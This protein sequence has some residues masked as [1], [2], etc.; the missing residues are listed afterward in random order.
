MRQRYIWLIIAGA[1]TVLVLACGGLSVAGYFVA[2]NVASSAFPNTEATFPE[3]Q[4]FELPSPAITADAAP[5]I[6]LE[7]DF[8]D[9]GSGWYTVTEPGVSIEYADGGYHFVLDE[10]ETGYWETHRSIRLRR[11][12]DVT[13]EVEARQVDGYADDTFGIVCRANEDGYYALEIGAD[14][15]Y[16]IGKMDGDEYTL[17]AGPDE[18]PG[19]E[20]STVDTHDIVLQR[21]ADDTYRLRADCIGD[22]LTLYADGEKIVEVKDDSFPMGGIGLAAYNYQAPRTE[23]VFD[24]IVVRT[25]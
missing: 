11:L 22:T 13:I 12:T 15:W 4:R 5:A 25:P 8:A 10:P 18:E 9:D 19:D 3:D 2:R 6:V 7:D 20:P 17:L 16:S 21:Q 24:N 1:V 14:G 23:I